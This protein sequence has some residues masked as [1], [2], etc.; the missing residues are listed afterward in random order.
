MNMDIT[1]FTVFKP[2]IRYVCYFSRSLLSL[3]KYLCCNIRITIVKEKKVEQNIY[4]C[5]YIYF[6]N[7]TSVSGTYFVDFIFIYTFI[8]LAL[9][10]HITIGFIPSV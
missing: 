5:V 4:I 10:G 7:N 8:I 3:T 6:L 1:R 9:A 2:C